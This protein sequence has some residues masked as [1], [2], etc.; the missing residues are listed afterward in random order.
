[1][2]GQIEPWVL[3]R[4]R[5]GQRAVRSF[6][7]QPGLVRLARCMRPNSSDLFWGLVI[8]AFAVAPFVLLALAAP[9]GDSPDAPSIALNDLA[10]AV[11]S[12]RVVSIEVT[13]RHGVATMGNG[14]RFGFRLGPGE[15]TLH[16]LRGLGVTPDE[17]SHV[18]YMVRGT[19]GIDA[20][21]AG[22]W[23]VL[24]MLLLGLLLLSVVRQNNRSEERRVGNERRSEEEME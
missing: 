10:R 17:L 8:L 9:S 23:S 1:M 3:F 12:E 16:V 14:D 5:S 11:Q 21:L 22:L 6:A 7:G 24:P 20:V 19:P 15:D 2:R 18:Q 4:R 13:D